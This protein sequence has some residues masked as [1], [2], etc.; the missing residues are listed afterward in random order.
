M[1]IQPWCANVWITVDKQQDIQQLSERQRV[2][3]TLNPE[4]MLAAE[5]P[6][7]PVMLKAKIPLSSF[8]AIAHEL[9]NTKHVYLED[10]GKT[11]RTGSAPV[12]EKIKN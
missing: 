6:I 3:Q 2:C 7:A 1:A 4:Y 8:D 9:L 12:A 10:P 11:R 5:E